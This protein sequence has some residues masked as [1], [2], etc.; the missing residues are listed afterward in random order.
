MLML[1]IISGETLPML[2]DTD[3]GAWPTEDFG[4]CHQYYEFIM[5]LD[6]LRAYNASVDLGC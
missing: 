5:G 4:I 3:P 6:I 1:Q 2:K